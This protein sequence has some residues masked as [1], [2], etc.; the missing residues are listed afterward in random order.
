MHQQSPHSGP[1]RYYESQNLLVGEA[2][3]K[4]CL[5]YAS[6]FVLLLDSKFADQ[7]EPP[8]FHQ[9][10]SYRHLTTENE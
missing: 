1:G 2:Q 8:S 9:R 3:T 10:H 5:A 6:L 7:H 4:V